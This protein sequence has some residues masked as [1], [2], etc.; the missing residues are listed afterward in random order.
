METESIFG[1]KNIT[2]QLD[3]YQIISLRWGSKILQFQRLILHEHIS[4]IELQFEVFY[5]YL[6]ECQ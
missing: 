4:I 1:Q 6:T 3:A 5:F 2:T